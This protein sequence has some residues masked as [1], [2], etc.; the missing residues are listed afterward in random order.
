MKVERI[1]SVHFPKSAGSSLRMQFIEFLADKVEL[2]YNHDPLTSAGADKAAFPVGKRIVH[3]HFRPDRY[4]IPDAFRMT[5]LR[6]PVDSIISIYYFWKTYPE[7]GNPVHEQFLREQ[8]DIFQFAR[9]PALSRLM[10]DTYF[11]GY[12]MTRFDFVGFHESR[13]RDIRRLGLMLDLPLQDV[14]VNRTADTPERLALLS[15]S[16]A[17]RRLRDL[18]AHDVAFYY[19]IKSYWSIRDHD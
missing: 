9:Y 1:V 3:G 17:K 7:H 8:P 18:L 10:S 11:G 14:H 16:V 15:D 2:D 6:D 19:Q 12:D 4:E 13:A 5:F